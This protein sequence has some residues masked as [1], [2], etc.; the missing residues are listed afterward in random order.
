MKPLGTYG[1][2]YGEALPFEKENLEIH[3][4][5]PKEGSEMFYERM[6]L[7]MAVDQFE[8]DAEDK[9]SFIKTDFAVDIY[10]GQTNKFSPSSFHFHN[11][12]EHTING[13][14]EEIAFHLVHYMN[15][16]DQE[17]DGLLSAFA[18]EVWLS[19]DDYDRSISEQDAMLIS[20][21]FESLKLDNRKSDGLYLGVK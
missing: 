6:N 15:A 18:I 5:N 21:F 13:K 11:P 12:T 16:P 2:A 3:Y 20:D 4:L 8:D 9:D 14:Y 10:G 17:E 1:W 7:K 19:V